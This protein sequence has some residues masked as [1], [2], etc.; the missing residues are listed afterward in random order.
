MNTRTAIDTADVVAR[1]RLLRQD[2]DEN[3]ERG[4]DEFGAYVD[5]VED[6]IVESGS[7]VMDL[8]YRQGANRV[9]KTMINFTQAEFGVLFAAVEGDLFAV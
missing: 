7:P 3:L 5:Y 9:L 1:L 6:E 4:T 8:L 2:E